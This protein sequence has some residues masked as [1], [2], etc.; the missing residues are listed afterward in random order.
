MAYAP[1]I[2]YRGDESLFR[3]IASAGKS[4]G[5][6]I[7]KFR[8]EQKSLKQQA[9]AAEIFFKELPEEQQTM[10]PEAF[11]NLSARDRVG[12]VSGM[13]QAAHLDKIK[14][15]ARGA[16]EQILAS[17][18]RRRVQDQQLEQEKS[19]AAAWKGFGG[20]FADFREGYPGTPLGQAV[21]Y[22]I[23]KNPEMMDQGSL[24][25]LLNYGEAGARGAM[26]PGTMSV[27]GTDI[28]YNP[29]TGAP[30]VLPSKPGSAAMVAQ[31]VKDGTGA[32]VP[33]LFNVGGKPIQ[34]RLAPDQTL[35][36]AKIQE[37]LFRTLTEVNQGI[38][39]WK[40]SA[41]ANIKKPNQPAPDPSLLK[42]YTEQR[43]GIL[44]TLRALGATP[45]PVGATNAPAARQGIERGPVTFQNTN[46]PGT[47]GTRLRFTSDG[48]LLTK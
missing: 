38:A 8:D 35:E 28:V 29:T 10:T 30:T 6:A 2:Q 7:E 22:A 37:G 26:Q 25:T 48:E 18:S 43:E 36:K 12:K 15:D 19:K 3:G 47:T 14:T 24:A 1:G 27:N 11:G 34:T 39:G 21:E 42:A 16:M 20:D 5:D 13:M 32:N 9:K 44:S 17:E 4:F 41:L 33:G 31:Q 46:A 23:T 45:Q 40:A